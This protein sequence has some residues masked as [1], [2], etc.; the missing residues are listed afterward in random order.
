MHNVLLFAVCWPLIWFV[1]L[2]NVSGMR[3]LGSQLVHVN[4]IELLMLAQASVWKTKSAGTVIDCVLFK[5]TWVEKL[6]LENRTTKWPLRD[7]VPGSTFNGDIWKKT[8]FSL[9]FC[10]KRVDVL[11][12][13]WILKYQSKVWR[14]FFKCF[15]KFLMLTKAAICLI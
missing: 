12:T 1:L 3:E 13:M 4:V 7:T 11:S 10:N 14:Q 2:E 5:W 9:L 8:R 15:L 6:F